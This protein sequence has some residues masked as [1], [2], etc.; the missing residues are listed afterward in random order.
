[1]FVF[2]K[3]ILAHLIADFVLQFEELYQLKVRSFLGQFFH[4]LIHG[5]V[6]LT[7][8]YP[9][10]NEFQ[11]RIFIIGIVCVHLLQDLLKYFFTRK[12]PSNTFFYFMVDQLCHIGVLSVILFFPASREIRGFQDS[13]FLDALYRT[14]AWTVGAI[15]FITLTFAGSYILNTFTKSYFRER[16]PLYLISSAEITHAIIERSFMAWILLTQTS[17]GMLFF[18]PAVGILRLPFKHL[19]D[20]TAF[21]LSFIYTL[22]VTILFYKIPYSILKLY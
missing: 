14:N 13:P 2:L 16:S 9:Y 7:L 11:I 15:F 17:W 21:F 18:V 10:L 22:L 3:L 4:A 1:M 6:S 8:L 19:R 20:L 5:L 12:T